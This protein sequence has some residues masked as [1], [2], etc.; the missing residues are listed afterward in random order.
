MNNFL[1]TSRKNTN[2][3]DIQKTIVCCSYL[4]PSGTRSVL[5]TGTLDGSPTPYDWQFTDIFTLFLQSENIYAHLIS[6]TLF[7]LTNSSRMLQKYYGI[8]R[9]MPSTKIKPNKF[10]VRYNCYSFDIVNLEKQD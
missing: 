5:A 8:R 1:W 6:I 2:R 9:R 7:H 3:S 10:F 4:L